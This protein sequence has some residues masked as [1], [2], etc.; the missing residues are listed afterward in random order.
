MFVFGW[1][2]QNLL[3]PANIHPYL[4]Q[5]FSQTIFDIFRRNNLQWFDLLTT[6]AIKAM[7]SIDSENGGQVTRNGRVSI[8]GSRGSHSPK[9]D[10]RDYAAAT[11]IF[12]PLKI[13]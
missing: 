6:Y 9:P 10:T 12:N 3:L 8:F 13:C 2:D 5:Y 4:Q 7:V 1:R 11:N